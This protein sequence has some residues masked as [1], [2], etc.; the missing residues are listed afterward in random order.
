MALGAPI[1][2]AL[3]GPDGWLGLRGWQIMYIAEATPTLLIGILT[4]FVLTDKPEQAR[5]PSAEEKGWL[6]GQLRTERTIKD[7]VRTFS[8]L[9]VLIDPKVLLLCP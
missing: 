7:A 5:F 6:T 8:L 3:L 1:S 2:T 4:L 9:E